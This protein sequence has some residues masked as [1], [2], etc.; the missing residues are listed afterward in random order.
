MV[1]EVLSL[2]GGCG[3]GTK[4]KNHVL[5][6]GP[7]RPASAPRQV[8]GPRSRGQLSPWEEGVRGRVMWAGGVAIGRRRGRVQVAG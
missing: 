6:H 1:F 3:F 7:D 2:G 5:N 8:E 4:V